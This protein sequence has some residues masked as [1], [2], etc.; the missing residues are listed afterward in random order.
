M[1]AEEITGNNADKF[2]KISHSHEGIVVGT[3]LQF[4]HQLHDEVRK[5][6]FVAKLVNTLIPEV[7]LAQK[8]FYADAGK[9]NPVNNCRA[10]R[11]VRI[12]LNLTRLI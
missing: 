12:M 10:R 1:L 5:S 3:K 2:L 7:I 8:S 4:S 11:I 9:M 6:G